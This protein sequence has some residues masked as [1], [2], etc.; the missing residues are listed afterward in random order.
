MEG[1]VRDGVCATYES[2]EFGGQAEY[3]ETVTVLIGASTGGVEVRQQWRQ[4][5]RVVRGE[6]GGCEWRTKCLGWGVC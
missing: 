3:G 5:K 1:C 4:G 2:R 6:W